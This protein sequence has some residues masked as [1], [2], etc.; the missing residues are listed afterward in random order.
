[1]RKFLL[2]VLLAVASIVSAVAVSD[3][4]RRTVDSCDYSNQAC[5]SDDYSD[6]VSAVIN[7]GLSADNTIRQESSSGS[8]S[9][10]QIQL[11]KNYPNKFLFDSLTSASL[12]SLFGKRLDIKYS[13]FG[14]CRF[15]FLIRVL[16]N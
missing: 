16:R 8:L 12:K 14:G 9:V 11:Q 13:L 4:D 6:Y 5:I 7:V 3:C 15:L 2:Y 1:M 10:V